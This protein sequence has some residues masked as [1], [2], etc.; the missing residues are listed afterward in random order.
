LSFALARQSKN[1][2]ARNKTSTPV[3]RS[4]RDNGV[5]ILT[6][7]HHDSIIQLQQ[8]I[9]NQAV[10]RLLRREVDGLKADYGTLSS[11][12]F[13]NDS[14]HVQRLSGQ[15]TITGEVGEHKSNP[16][17]PSLDASVL[18]DTDVPTPAPSRTPNL[19]APSCTI[20]T[21]TLVAAPDGTADTRKVVGVNEEVEM[22]AS[23]LATWTED[24]GTTKPLSKTKNAKFDKN[25][26]NS[27]KALWTAPAVGGTFSV[28]AT[29]APDS[30]CSV[31]MKVLTPTSRSLTK[32]RDK[33]KDYKAGLAGSGFDASITYNPTNV[34]FIRTLFREEEANANALGY[35]EKRGL[36]NDLH[37]RGLWNP[38]KANNVG[39]FADSVGTDPVRNRG[40]TSGPF[41]FV[42]F[43]WKIPQTFKA[44]GAP[45][46]DASQFSVAEQFQFM[47]PGESGR[48]TTGKEGEEH[49]R[50][51]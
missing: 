39:F 8:T 24:G 41:S 23:A 16:V 9:G 33:D 10:Q 30:P 35:Y 13:A 29:P 28:T 36:D 15:T 6:M 46:S 42:I 44:L 5:N 1:E 49:T 14:S 43:F 31:S 18:K 17:S 3:K 25:L 7:N 45:D 50:T 22:T 37:R 20:S 38:V 21:R 4:S 34:S 12:H 51:P 2:Q 40:G 19:L 48:E 27:T 26:K 47:V 32:V 11:P